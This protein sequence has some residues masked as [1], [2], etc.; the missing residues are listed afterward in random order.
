M[1]N[2]VATL[3]KL[4]TQTRLTY[5]SVLLD[6]AEEPVG[7]CADTGAEV[8]LIS[9]VVLDKIGIKYDCDALDD[10][11]PVKGI[12]HAPQSTKVI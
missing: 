4:P 5:L 2:T 1:T 3:Q 12:A 9:T 8:S 10:A 11:S 7:A 6:D